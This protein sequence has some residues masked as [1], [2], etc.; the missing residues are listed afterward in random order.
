MV[1]ILISGGVLLTMDAD[2]RRFENGAV[3]I[4]GST[5]LDV[6]PTPV[7]EERYSPDRHIDAAGMVV[8]PGLINCHAHISDILFRG[9]IGSDRELYDWLYNVKLP[10]VGAMTREEHA[11][12]SGLFATE[13]IQA[14]ATTVVENAVGSGSGYATDIVDAKVETYGAAGIRNVYGQSFIDADPD[15]DVVEFIELEMKKEP[16]VDHV[17]PES[18]VCDTDDGFENIRS[19]IDRHHG[20][21]DGRQS[22]WPAPLFPYTTTDEGLV[23]CLEIADEHDVMVTTHVAET[24]HELD[25]HHTPVEYLDAIGFLGERALLGHC[26]YLSDRD[27]RLLAETGTSVSHNPLTNLALGA[28]V[29]P[30]PHM[31]DKGVTVGLGTDNSSGSDTA[32]MINDMRFGALIH[33]GSRRDPTVMSAERALSMATIEAA[34]AIGREDDLG[35][36]EPGKKADIALLDLDHPHLTPHRDVVSTIVYQAQGFEVD[37][38]LCNGDIVMEDRSVHGIENRYPELTERAKELSATVVERAGLPQPPL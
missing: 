11:I 5:I 23:G 36:I 18:V 19:L 25:G 32:N 13:L 24:E 14:G 31:I 35:S 10:G 30:V 2:G 6:G 34:R 28:G 15:P 8:F 7:L 20:A 22:V 17:H 27:I 29:A 16:T 26:V 1:D 12:A 4:D 21:N 9:G 37:T 33:K 38:V 3:A